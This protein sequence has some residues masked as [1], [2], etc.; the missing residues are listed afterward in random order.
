[1]HA[2]LLVQ[3]WYRFVMQLGVVPLNGT[4]SSSHMASDLQVQQ[5]SQPLSDAEMKDIGATIGEQLG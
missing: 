2:V 1:M 4:S 3:V 5:W